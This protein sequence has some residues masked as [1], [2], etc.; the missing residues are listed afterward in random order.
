MERLIDKKSSKRSR[1]KLLKV[2]D[3][4]TNEI[5]T[6]KNKREMEKQKSYL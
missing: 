4:N 3:E 1:K 5:V 2:A 6:R